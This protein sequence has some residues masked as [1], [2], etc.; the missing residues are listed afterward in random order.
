M[1]EIQT[2]VDHKGTFWALLPAGWLG[3][4]LLGLVTTAWIASNDPS[5]ALERDYY[6]KAIT[7]DA[8]QAQAAENERLGFRLDVPEPLRSEP[9]GSVKVSLQLADAAG[10]PVSGAQVRAE[11]FANARADRISNLNFEEISAGV[12]STELRS[13]RSGLWELRCTVLRG[14]DRF[15]SVVR[16]DV[17]TSSTK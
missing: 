6:Q 11:A 15:T 7:W 12:Y 16:R 17:V 10:R 9:N 5:F 4:V 8:T 2:E 1:N 14:A 3:L 13:A